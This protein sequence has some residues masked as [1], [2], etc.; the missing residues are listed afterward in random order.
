[1]DRWRTACLVGAIPTLP[2]AAAVVPSLLVVL[3]V[4]PSP[5]P[6]AEVS[7]PLAVLILGAA[8]APSP[9]G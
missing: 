2:A 9:E 3:A 5:E 1:M 7:P 8:A 4:L 6:V